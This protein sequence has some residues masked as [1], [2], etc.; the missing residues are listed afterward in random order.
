MGEKRPQEAGSSVLEACYSPVR[1][2][3]GPCGQR[4][5]ETRV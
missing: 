5:L 3:V 1:D 2:S 4:L